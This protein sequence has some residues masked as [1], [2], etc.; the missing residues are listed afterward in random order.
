MTIRNK[1]SLIA[2][3]ALLVC[4]AVIFFSRQKSR[5]GQVFLQAVPFQTKYGWGYD[6]MA[7]KRKYI[8]QQFI[9]AIPG[10]QGF[11]SADDALLVGNLVITKIISRQ[12]PTITI[13]DL[14][15]LGLMK[16]SVSLK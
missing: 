5:E 14:R 2:I 4:F 12:E 10:M 9:P 15:D 8:E 1:Y 11:K 6:I 16:D 7:G 3:T 13:K